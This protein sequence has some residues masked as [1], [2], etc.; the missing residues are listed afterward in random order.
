MVDFLTK[1]NSYRKELIQKGIKKKQ[2]NLEVMVVLKFM[3]LQ[4][5]A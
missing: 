4:G 3:Q 5:V 1:Y 2:G